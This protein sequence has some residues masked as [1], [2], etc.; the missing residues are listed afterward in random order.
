MIRELGRPIA[1]RLFGFAVVVCVLLGGRWI[2]FSIQ[3]VG[4]VSTAARSEG[5]D[6]LWL[7]HCPA[8]GCRRGSAR[9]SGR[10]AR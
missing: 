4:S 10:S 5:D 9:R 7:S 8:C 3:D 2:A 1:S 6:G